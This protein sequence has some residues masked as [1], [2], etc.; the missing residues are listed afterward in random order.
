MDQVGIFLFKEIVCKCKR[1]FGRC[2]ATEN[3]EGDHIGVCTCGE[4]HNIQKENIKHT[5]EI[6]EGRFI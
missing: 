6:K 3:H 4:N 5:F 1:V 2:R